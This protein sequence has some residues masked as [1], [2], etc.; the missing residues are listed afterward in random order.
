MM[1]T[2]RLYYE[3]VMTKEFE[4]KVLS[5]ELTKEGWSV[6]LDRTAFYPEGGGQPADHGVLGET[7]VKD[8]REEGET[9][10][11][12]TEGPLETGS[13]VQGKIDWDRRFDLMQQH[14]GEHLVSGIIHEMFGY[15]NVG[16]HMG[17]E[18]ITIDLSGPLHETDISGIEQRVNQ[19]IWENHP[20]QVLYPTPQELENM[21]Y[22][23]K[24]ELTGDVR[25]VS[26][27]GGDLC[28]CCGLHVRHTGEIGLVKIVSVR[29]FH[30]GVRIEMLCGGRA[31]RYLNTHF[32]QN[33]KVS[34]RLSVK[35]DESVQALEKLFAENYRLRGELMQAEQRYYDCLASECAG[36]GD[37][38]VITRAMAP[39]AIQHCIDTIL[40]S[41]G[42]KAL[43]FSGDDEEGYRFAAGERD[44]DVRSLAASIRERLGGKG[45]GKPFFVQGMV[46]NERE[47]IAN[48]CKEEKF[49]IFDA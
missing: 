22:R 24:K 28:A 47:T 4:A 1:Q 39:G 17:E 48:F 3:D 38:A 29:K 43:L 42:G 34:V 27:P 8:V 18:M 6:I 15:D 45:G 12:I 5:C 46:K 13:F 23:S 30:E 41:C 33:S 31:L 32:E 40:S 21:P 37:V 26:F 35:P 11:H 20:S 44:G 36:K 19:Y 9:V 49:T 14:S 7:K 16:F 2:R 25:I 10:V